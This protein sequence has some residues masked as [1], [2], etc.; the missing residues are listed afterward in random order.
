MQRQER[1]AEL[2]AQ[3]ARPHLRIFPTREQA[4]ARLDGGLKLS[5]WMAGWKRRRPAGPWRGWRSRSSPPAVAPSSTCPPPTATPRQG[6]D[7]LFKCSILCVPGRASQAAEETTGIIGPNLN[8]TFGIVRAQ[9][10]D[11]STIR[12][13]VRGRIAYPETK[14]AEG[15]QRDAR[16]PRHGSG[17]PGTSRTSSPSA[18]C[19]RRRT[20]RTPASPAPEPPDAYK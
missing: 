8:S 1:S 4:V 13:V 6:Q 9:D 12:D 15:G 11:V 19:S 3:R 2:R 10:F 20:R 16:R 5:A 17:R 7:P 18:R 14:T